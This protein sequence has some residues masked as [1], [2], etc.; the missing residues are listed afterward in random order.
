MN[1]DKFSCNMCCKY[2]L[3]LAK[4]GSIY[5]SCECFFCSECYRDSISQNLEKIICISCSN[6]IDKFCII[7]TNIVEQ[8]KNIQ[9]ISKRSIVKQKIVLEFLIVNIF[10]LILG[11]KE[12][13]IS[14]ICSRIYKKKY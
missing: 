8:E 7:D 9:H 2:N 1:Q 3:Y 12:T 10:L 5:C 13:N 6:L 14:K 4:N 11:K